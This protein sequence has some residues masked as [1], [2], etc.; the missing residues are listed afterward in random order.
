[1]NQSLGDS[2]SVILIKAE[3][4]SI[5]NSLAQKDELIKT[6]KDKIKTLEVRF[7]FILNFILYKKNENSLTES[8]SNIDMKKSDD[9]EYYKKSFDEQKSRVNKEHEV[10]ASSLYELTIQFMS[11][12]TELQKR[13]SSIYGNKNS[14]YDYIINYEVNEFILYKFVNKII[15]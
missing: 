15:L 6:L 11:L 8:N 7:K 4:Q 9:V 12:K 1:M 14:W 5:K 13:V 10:I 2:D 3:N